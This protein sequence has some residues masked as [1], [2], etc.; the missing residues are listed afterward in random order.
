MKTSELIGAELDYHV[1][2]AEGLTLKCGRCGGALAASQD[3]GCVYGDCS[4]RGEDCKIPLKAAFIVRNLV[5]AFNPS[6]YWDQCG[7]LLIKYPI[8]ITIHDQRRVVILQ[9]SHDEILS[10]ESHE[11][12]ENILPAICR[13]IVS[14]VY[15]EEV[16]S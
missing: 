9:G 1:A 16:E 3:K 15:G 2:K 7:P 10:S 11:M 8:C 12:D 13:C 4:Y 5:G 14:S 6:S